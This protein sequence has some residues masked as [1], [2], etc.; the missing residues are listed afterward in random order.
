MKRICL[1][2]LVVSA[3]FLTSCNF[4]LNVS[5]TAPSAGPDASMVSGSL[6]IPYDFS[7][8]D[9]DL[10][11]V[12]LDDDY[13]MTNGYAGSDYG[14][15]YQSIQNY[16]YSIAPAVPAGEYVLYAYMDNYEGFVSVDLISTAGWMKISMRSM[17][18]P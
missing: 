7:L 18:V 11:V 10:W 6:R 12:I 8:N 1:G 17:T 9:S 5:P 4:G 14:W 3:W 16:A 15:Y 13:D 2:L